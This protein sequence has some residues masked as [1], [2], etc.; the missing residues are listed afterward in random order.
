MSKAVAPCGMSENRVKETE[1][2]IQWQA[3][4]SVFEFLIYLFK[5]FASNLH[6]IFRD[7]ENMLHVRYLF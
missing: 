5:Y 7:I 4:E 1:N 2:T 3:F 6:S